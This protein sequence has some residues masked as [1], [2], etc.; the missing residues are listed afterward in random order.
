MKAL[1]V[2]SLGLAITSNA[3]ADPAA[4]SSPRAIHSSITN[5]WKIDRRS[6][7]PGE[8]VAPWISE[9][10]SGAASAR[11]CLWDFTPNVPAHPPLSGQ[12]IWQDIEV[13][14]DGSKIGIVWMDD[15]TFSYHVYYAQSTDDGTTW[16]SPPEVVDTRVGGNLSRFPDLEFAPSGI[17]V[18]I[19]EDDRQG[20]SG[21]NVYIS[22]RTGGAPP[23]STNIRV[24]DAGTPPGLS[25]FMNSS[26]A[27]LTETHFFVAW[28]D[29][30]EG[31]LYQVYMSSTTNSGAT[32]STPAV[33]V[34]DEL[35]FDP[36]AGDPNLAVDPTSNPSSASLICLTNDW[37]GDVPGGRYPNVF[38]YRSTNGGASWSTGVQ[39]NDVSAFYQQVTG[40]SIVILNNGTRTAGWFNSP[41][42]GDDHLHTNVSTNQGVT[43]SLSVPADPAGS[44]V[45]PSIAS[46]GTWVF[47][48]FDSYRNGWDIYFRASPDG[49]RSWTEDACRIDDD[50]TGAPSQTPVIAIGPTSKAYATW[51]DGRPGF[52]TWKTYTTRVTSQVTAVEPLASAPA[53]GI[54]Q[55]S[56]NPSYAGS[57]VRIVLP[58]GDGRVQIF[59]TAGR[60]V[61][62]VASSSGEAHWDGKDSGGKESAPG[63]YFLSLREDQRIQGELIRVR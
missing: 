32:W 48:A 39:V 9:L 22:R 16:S 4:S 37:R 43:W 24:N 29:W 28:T 35:G 2:V 21:M 41:T 62:E 14:P 15:H 55:C 34:S 10:D 18:V 44:G 56:P 36:V 47:A 27:I 60:L 3:M 31:P 13:S 63:V 38:A 11:A 17:P 42:A 25:D 33:R 30:R 20:T 58:Y 45:Y 54:L 7:G 53:Q 52:G 6:P 40:H 61:R 50:A 12:A 57:P 59:D 19:W 5:T 26:L 8:S 23:W 46:N 49:G 51:M 1:L